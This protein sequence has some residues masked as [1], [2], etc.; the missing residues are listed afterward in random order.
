MGNAIPEDEIIGYIETLRPYVVSC[1]RQSAITGDPTSNKEDLISVGIIAMFKVL[2][3]GTLDD[4]SHDDRIRILKLVV[5]R[6]MIDET[7][8]S[9]THGAKLHVP[10]NEVIDQAMPSARY[11]SPREYALLRE[12]YDLIHSKLSQTTSD[13][14]RLFM[15]PDSRLI[16]IV[17]QRLWRGGHKVVTQGDLALRL[18]LPLPIIRKAL[19]ELVL[20]SQTD[21]SIS[22][23]VKILYRLHG[24]PCVIEVFRDSSRI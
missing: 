3:G 7:R 5:R 4:K 8:R 22:K 11:I 13:I 6:R 1:A 19:D 24:K 15:N 9:T 20:I 14:L 18:G 12:A 23:S 17:K 10:I 21:R 2:M 16:Q